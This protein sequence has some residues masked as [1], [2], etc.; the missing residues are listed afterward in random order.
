ME[1]PTTKSQI[2]TAIQAERL[3]LETLLAKIP[4]AQMTL[5]DLHE[6]WSVKDI[7]AHITAWEE[8]MQG[9]VQT[10]LRGETPDRPA[11]GESWEELDALNENMHQAHKDRPLEEVLQGFHDSHQQVLEMVN[12]LSEDDLLDPQRFAWRQ[13]DPLWH[14][15]AANTWW[16]YQE[17]RETIAA[18]LKSPAESS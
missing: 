5:P 1:E 13:G 18:W 17:H 9:W 4:P 15:V 12:G 2:L 11:P 8:L 16:H 10:S 7:L 3:A 6:G 14:L